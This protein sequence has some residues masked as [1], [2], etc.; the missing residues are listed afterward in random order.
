MGI[1]VYSFFW[2]MQDLY[3]HPPTLKRRE[4]G[5]GRVLGFSVWLFGFV[6]GTGVL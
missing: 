6:L 5:G 4:W 1:M 2:V 3:Q